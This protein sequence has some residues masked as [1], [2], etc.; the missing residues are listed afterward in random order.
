MRRKKQHRVRDT[1]ALSVCEE[2]CINTALLSE[3][4]CTTLGPECNSVTD[5]LPRGKSTPRAA[6]GRSKESSRGR[7]ERGL[8][9]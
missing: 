1:A 4:Q 9:G 7:G 5:W 2:S 3:Q 6:S 8:G